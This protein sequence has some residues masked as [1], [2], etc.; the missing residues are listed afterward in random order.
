[1]ITNVPLWVDSNERQLMI[2]SFP[3]VSYG[4][5]RSYYKTSHYTD[6]LLESC[7]L[8]GLRLWHRSLRM[9]TN[10]KTKQDAVSVRL[11]YKVVEGLLSKVSFYKGLKEL[12]HYQLLL[13]TNVP[14][15]Y[16]VNI[17][18]AHKLNA[19]K[20]YP[21]TAITN[22]KPVSSDVLECEPAYDDVRE[23]SL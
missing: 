11:T 8:S 1:M 9:L 20:S 13:E 21:E 6:E 17:Q 19:P 10:N 4:H 5:P 12:L 23:L 15:T 18:H 7:S 16:V 22:H 2:N 3:H 14:N